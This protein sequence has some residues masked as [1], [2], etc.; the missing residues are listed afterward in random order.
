MLRRKTNTTPD[1]IIKKYFNGLQLWKDEENDIDILV[2][3]V[4][5][6]RPKSPKKI[7]KLDRKSVV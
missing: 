4:N 5:A 1:V 3:L 6:I 7:L 2:Q